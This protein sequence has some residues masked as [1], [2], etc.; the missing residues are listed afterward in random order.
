MLT[1]DI[2]GFPPFRYIKLENHYGLQLQA[3][4]L[5]V[6]NGFTFQTF[7]HTGMRIEP[8]EAKTSHRV[9]LGRR[10]PIVYLLAVFFP[11][12]LFTQRICWQQTIQFMPPS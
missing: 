7:S 5:E 8:Y 4:R 2:E 3:L 10:F 11:S 1:P 6:I 12:F 9:T